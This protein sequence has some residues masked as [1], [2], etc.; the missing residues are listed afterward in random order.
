MPRKRVLL[1]VDS[2]KNTIKVKR[3]RLKLSSSIHDKVDPI[4]I[5][6][7]VKVYGE[8]GRLITKDDTGISGERIVVIIA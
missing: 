1:E 4:K 7:E 3:P 5:D 6:L 2:N 8:V